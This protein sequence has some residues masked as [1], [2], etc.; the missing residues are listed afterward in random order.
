MCSSERIRG[1]GLR[2]QN[3]HHDTLVQKAMRAA[4]A[5]RVV[6][7]R[8]GK[9]LQQGVIPLSWHNQI[10]GGS[11]ELLVRRARALL[12]FE[13]RRSGDPSVPEVPAWFGGQSDLTLEQSLVVF[14]QLS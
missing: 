7:P 5:T 2:F 12:R 14:W 10:Q 1:S 4:T 13:T 11:A 8:G 6:R 9:L 3:H